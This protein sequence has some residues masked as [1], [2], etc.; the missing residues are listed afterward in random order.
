MILVLNCVIKKINKNRKDFCF[1]ASAAFNVSY[2]A[3]TKE[4]K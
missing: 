3:K 2:D 4:N 1:I